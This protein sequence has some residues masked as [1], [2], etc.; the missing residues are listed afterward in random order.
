MATYTRSNAW[1]N[2][3]TFANSDLLWYAKGVG[4]M[5]SRALDDPGSW[6]FFA[7]IH[8]QYVTG[9]QSQFP[10]WSFIP[11][12]PKVPTSPIPTQ[13]V[14]DLY[15]DQCQH[16]SWFF[17]P[18]HRG[19][20]IALEAQVRAAVVGLGGPSTWALPYWD[21]FGPA[22]QYEIP[23]AF[24]Q[25]SLPDGSPNPLFVTARYGP[26]NDG[27]IFIPIP[28]VSQSCMTNNLFTG[29]NSVTPRPGFGGPQT[30]FSHSGNRSGNLENNPHNIVHVDVGGNGPAPIYGLM[31]D[32][33]TAA[34]DPIFYLHHC[35][36]DRMWAVWN[37]QGNSNPSVPDW[38]NGPASIG[39]RQF[40]MPM[41]GGKS[42][43][44]TPRELTSLSPLDYTY[45]SLPAAAPA[46][47]PP[48]ALTLRL[49]RL[50]AP[51][52]AAA[53]ITPSAMDSSP[54]SELVGANDGTLQIKGSG[55][56][57][58]VKLDSGIRKRVAASLMAASE[59]APP[60]R[61]YLQLENV[62]GTRDAHKLNVYVNEHLAGT[63]ALFG[64]RQA[65]LK[66]GQHGGSGLTFELDITPIIDTLHL[67]NTL[68]QDSLDVRITPTHSIP[69]GAGITVGRVSVYREAVQ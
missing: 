58:T 63:V 5:Q 31:S 1:N 26:N 55:A 34:L 47:T 38:L 51:A 16:Q 66:D 33:G 52:A 14:Q 21:Y 68:G 10:D 43:I 28:P 59:A 39:Q 64:L 11:P 3:G 41:P 69:D 44:Y 37:A 67:E 18:W 32:P 46:P 12:A 13:A 50:G 35:N 45:D 29:S 27:N 25:S 17:L 62:R 57:A 48:K 60:D 65:S 30:G 54:K 22:N 49:Q 15:W 42:W 2:Q 61:A 56:R 53:S 7:A 4:V 6:W 24:T 9:Q 19:Y 8:G 36:I 20:L 23:P 40:A